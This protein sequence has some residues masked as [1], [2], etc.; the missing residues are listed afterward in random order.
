LNNQHKAKTGEGLK[1]PMSGICP[2]LIIFL[3]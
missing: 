3:V 1:V 2:L